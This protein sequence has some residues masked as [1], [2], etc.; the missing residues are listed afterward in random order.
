MGGSGS[1]NWYRWNTKGTVEGHRS[2]DLRQL[3]R[4]GRLRPRYLGTLTWSRNGEV[5]AS[6]GWTVHGRGDTVTDLEL[7][8][9][10]TSRSTG[11]AEDVRYRVPITYTRCHYGGERPWFRCP[12]VG[13]GRRVAKLYLG[14]RYFACRHCLHLAYASQRENETE[15]AL[16]KAQA[17]RIRLGGSGNMMDLFPPKPR[18]MHWATYWRLRE[19][20]DDAYEREIAGL[21][22]SAWLDKLERR[23]RR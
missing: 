16:S 8:Y 15:R 18:S 19:Q 11:A 2:I 6:I 21:S 5:V 12:A 17:I 10:M 7:Y 3:H 23:T 4:E 14:S 13:C 20:Y 22:A 1:G 9:T